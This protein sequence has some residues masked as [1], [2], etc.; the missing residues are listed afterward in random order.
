MFRH[1]ELICHWAA[2]DAARLELEIR[3]RMPLDPD[4]PA[5]P[6]YYKLEQQQQQQQQPVG[7]GVYY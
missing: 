4:M 1:S 7:V 6:I 2:D 5:L 3:R